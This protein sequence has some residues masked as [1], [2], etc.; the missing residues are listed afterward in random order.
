M[1]HFSLPHFFLLITF[2]EYKHIKKTDTQTRSQN[3][4][5]P[6][7]HD[8][9]EHEH[10]L[11]ERRNNLTVDHV[12]KN[13]FLYIKNLIFSLYELALQT[14]THTQIYI[15]GLLYLIRI[16]CDRI[17]HGNVTVDSL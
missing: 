17:E 16:D 5:V 4:T 7:G 12:L 6:V 9:N 10:E 14:H 2:N 3:I 11:N 8:L 1:R 15:Y 13:S